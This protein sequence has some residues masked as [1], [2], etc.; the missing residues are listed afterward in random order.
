MIEIRRELCTG[1]GLC[2]RVC[3]V[4]A[5]ALRSGKAEIDSERCV[6]CE[7]CLYAC[8]T[9]AILYSSPA[10]LSELRGRLLRLKQRIEWI[11]GKLN[12]FRRVDRPKW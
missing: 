12:R 3:P 2:T 4:G 7:A 6:S 8:P 10:E 9:H 5:V 11:Q 1:C